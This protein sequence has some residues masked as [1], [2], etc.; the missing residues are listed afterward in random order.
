MAASPLPIPI[1]TP[2]AARAKQAADE[3]RSVAATWARLTVG[4]TIA[5]RDEYD[6]AASDLHTVKGHLTALHEHRMSLTRPLDQAR[7]GIIALF[8]PAEV[9]LQDAEQAIKAA[10]VTFIAEE[11]KTVRQKNLLLQA[12]A[13]ADGADFSPIVYYEPPRTPGVQQ[14]GTWSAEVDDFRALVE[15][16]AEGKAPLN[17]LL[18]NMPALNDLARSQRSALALPG[19]RAA[20]RH[21]IAAAAKQAE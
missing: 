3:V 12:A 10:M 18:P 13:E 19:V 7:K 21:S 16:V 11:A 2:L 5:N 1:T 17:V 9:G 6:T 8:K 14:R 15:A 4:Y 20:R